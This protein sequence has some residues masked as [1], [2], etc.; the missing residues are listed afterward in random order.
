LLQRP[1]PEWTVS[2]WLRRNVFQPRHI[3]G[4]AGLA[5][6]NAE[7]EKLAMDSQRSPQRLAMLIFQ[8]SQ[9]ISNRTVGRPQRC[10][11]FQRQYELKPTRCQ[12]MTVSGFTIVSA[13][14]AFGTKRHSPTEIRRSMALKATLFGTCRRWMLMTKNQDLSLQQDPRAE[15]GALHPPCRSLLSANQD[16]A[17]AALS[18]FRRQN[19]QQEPGALAALAGICAGS[20]SNPC[21]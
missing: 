20:G 11:D 2:E 8:I 12:R 1:D 13:L 15:Q 21:L 5:D 10:R 9:R 14:M 6:P 3:F 17:S 19:P 4:N 16:T 18:P 7:L